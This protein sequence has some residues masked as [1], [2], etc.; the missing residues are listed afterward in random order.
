M[1]TTSEMRDK[2]VAELQ[3]EIFKISKELFGLNMQKASGEL[4]KTDL[5]KKSRREKARLKTII[6]EKSR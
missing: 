5:I 3:E 6:S 1:M 2:S 4:Q